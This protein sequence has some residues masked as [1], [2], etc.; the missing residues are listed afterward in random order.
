MPENPAPPYARIVADITARI[1]DGRLAPGEAVPSTRALAAQWGVALATATKALAALRAK[2]LVRAIP[3]SGTVVAD[4]VGPARPS[5]GGEANR[6]GIVA[7]AIALA[8]SDGLAAVSMRAVAQ[9]LGSAPMSLYRHVEGKADLVA[10]MTDAA[11]AELAFDP[12]P[13]G[14]WR[15]D[16]EAVARQL[17]R[18]FRRHT[19]LP[20]VVSLTRV[21]PLSQVF[22]YVDAVMRALRGL[23]A[24]AH[25]KLRIHMALYGYVQGLAAGLENDRTPA[26]AVGL[27]ETEWDADAESTM[28]G[29]RESGDYPD[30]VAVIDALESDY[31]QD[32]DAIFE[33]GLRVFLNGL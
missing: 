23:D 3:R 21:Q 1:A 32:L 31:E 25:T 2:G 20:Q 19:W 4:G 6:R 29:L 7:A 9:R 11:F 15:A 17:W 14:R 24:D 28:A 10:Y 27:G 30:F 5:T 8:D 12:E 22:R 18:L 13:S 33:F 26:G 16:L